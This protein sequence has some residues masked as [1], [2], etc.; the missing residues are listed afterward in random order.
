MEARLAEEGAVVSRY[1]PVETQLPFSD[2]AYH[3][4]PGEHPDRAVHDLV[5]TA[6]RADAFI[7]A[8]PIYHNS[9]SGVLKNALD[10]LAIAQFQYKPVALLSHGGDRSSQA[11]DQ[12]RT[13]VR[14]L[15][16]VPIPTPICTRE[17]DFCVRD[18]E[19]ALNSAAIAARIE[20]AVAELTVF[21]LTC[22]SARKRL[23][24]R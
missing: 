19:I 7:L 23:L 5:E 1:D 15:L 9:F 22:R 4:S 8:S 24:Q 10:H 12:L 2:P 13:V 18:A 20:R 3:K 14:G 6:E 16:G 11:V 21:A 17:A